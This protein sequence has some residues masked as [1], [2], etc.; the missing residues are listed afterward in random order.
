MTPPVLA[1]PSF[2]VDFTLETDA[3][4][5]GLG[6]IWSQLQADGKLHLVTYAS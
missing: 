6:A 2:D 5:K 1:Y 4:M 3:L